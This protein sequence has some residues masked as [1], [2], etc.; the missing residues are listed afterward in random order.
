MSLA[1]QL[2]EDVAGVFLDT[3]DFA[4]TILHYP[5]G[6]EQAAVKVT[7]IVTWYPEQEEFGRGRATMRRGEL[8]LSS[9][10]KVTVKDAWRI[11]GH[12]YDTETI[13]SPQYDCQTIKI[14]RY[15]PETKAGLPLRTGEF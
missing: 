11:D 14:Q 8:F 13:S 2:S 15:L 3:N 4:V 9:S 5:G 6:V 1:D 7:A 12:R 10:V